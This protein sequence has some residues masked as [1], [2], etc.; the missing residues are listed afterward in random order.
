MKLA[1]NSRQMV[2]S[3]SVCAISTLAVVLAAA[4]ASTVTA[5][6]PF[7]GQ[8]GSIK[9]RLVWGGDELPKPM[10]LEVT[11]DT[12]FCGMGPMVSKELVVDPTTKG[13]GNAFA[14]LLSPVGT[15]PEA[16]KALL[17]GAAEVAIDQRKCEYVP[18]STAM[19]QDQKLVFKSSDN[20]NHNV[21]YAAFTNSPFNQVLPPKGEMKVK[22]VAEK[23]PIP[24][25]CD[26]HPWMKGSIMVFD[27][28]F[29]AVTKED[30]SFEIQGVPPGEQKL[31][32]RLANGVFV[33]PDGAHTVTVKVEAGKAS[34]VEL[35]IDPKIIRK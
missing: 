4:C 13:V 10:L 27:H 8:F 9:G 23:R 24:L 28:P 7:Q 32:L 25:T 22:L 35:K 1:Q 30:G 5:A 21:H 3:V 18:Y 29:F 26:L 6:P 17:A 19:H 33:T 31:I 16:Q 34:E 12:E 20:V 14:Y 2:R 11:K 15:N